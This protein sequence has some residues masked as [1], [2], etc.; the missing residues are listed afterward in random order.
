MILWVTVQKWTKDKELADGNPPGPGIIHTSVTA[1][2]SNDYLSAISGTGL[3]P[4]RGDFGSY[5]G[6]DFWY[7]MLYQKK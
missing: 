4:G 2:K 6:R 3:W 7:N 1:L 5:T